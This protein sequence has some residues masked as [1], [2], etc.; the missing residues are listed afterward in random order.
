M[1]LLLYFI[2][3]IALMFLGLPVAIA[4][5]VTA[6]AWVISSGM[7]LIIIPD[8]FFAG[9]DAFVLMAI[10]FFMVAGET[11]NRAD[12][13]RKL[14]EF[15]NFLVGR[16]RGGLAYVNIVT[17][18]IFS[19]ITG[20]AVADV[21]ALGTIF[22][23]SMEKD[24]YTKGYAAAV[25][26]ASSIVGPIIPPS[27]VIVVY[28]AIT[29]TSVAALF[30]AAIVPGLLIG[31]IQ[32]IVVFI[33]AKH[34]NFPRQKVDFTPKQFILSFKD[35]SLA[36]IM[37]LII[38]GGIL[39]GITTPTEAAA[40]ACLYAFILGVFVYRKL[41][42]IDFLMIF[43]RATYQYTSLLVIMGAASVLGWILSRS[44]AHMA[45]IKLLFGLTENPK[46][47]L[48][49]VIL[50]LLFVGTWLE[51][52]ATIVLLA[53]TLTAAMALIGY[54]PIHFGTIM[55][56]AVN[57]GLITPPLGVCLFAASGTGNVAVED[58]VREI[59]PYIGASVFVLFIIAF[60]PEIVYFIP[61]LLG[62]I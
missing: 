44:Q 57:I 21:S 40:I 22:I 37:P 14:I 7:P 59:W 9:M 41:T 46:L 6:S 58:I 10:P 36:L 3:L 38:L 48:A 25:T 28:G 4:I 32:G 54:Q 29:N 33:Q 49:I 34:R 56:L 19:G 27:I 2:L 60:F 13:T 31:L 1:E 51:T 55:I 39:F 20:A 62:L 16:F 11:M 50:F 30:A 26:A 8:K 43:K 24:G 53:P 5:G 23:P 15:A 45:L 35:A 61:R 12:I 17:S 42:L 18:L 52:N 47:I